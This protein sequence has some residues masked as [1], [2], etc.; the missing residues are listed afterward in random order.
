MRQRTPKIRSNSR[1]R[2]RSFSRSS[3]LVFVGTIESFKNGPRNAFHPAALKKKT[4]RARSKCDYLLAAAYVKHFI[5]TSGP[6]VFAKARRLAS[7]RLKID[8]SEFQH[9]L[10]LGH[11]RPSKSDYASPLHIVPSGRGSRVV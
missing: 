2:N 8:K 3:N 10:N 1:P 9:M 11:I 6:P 5:E 4:N 7:D